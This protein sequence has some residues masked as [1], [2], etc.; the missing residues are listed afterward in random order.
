MNPQVPVETQ[1]PAHHGTRSD[2]LMY[3]PTTLVH[4]GRLMQSQSMARNVYIYCM[5][6]GMGNKSESLRAP[7]QVS[8]CV[9]GVHDAFHDPSQSCAQQIN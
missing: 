8:G 4:G 9:R 5:R 7:V 2:T 6:N 1:G 3:F